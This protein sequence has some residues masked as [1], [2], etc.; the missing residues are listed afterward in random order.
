MIIFWPICLGFSGRFRDSYLNRFFCTPFVA[1]AATMLVLCGPVFGRDLS[2]TALRLEE[3]ATSQ[4]ET[5]H[6]NSMLVDVLVD[7]VPVFTFA[8]GEAMPGVPVTRE[9]HFRNGAVAL[10]YIG[11]LAL[12][13]E[14]EELV[15]LEA[16]IDRWLPDLPGADKASMRMLINMT[17]GYP[18]HVAN[19]DFIKAFYA[20]P[21]RH[22]T[23]EELIT[24]S[25]SVERRFV[26]GGNWDYSH[27][28]YVILGRVLEAATDTPLDALL[29]Q[30]VL[31]PLGLEHTRA[32]VTPEIPEPVVHA[33]TAER[34]NWEDS[35][36]WHPSWT[37][38]E[39]AVQVTTIAEMARSFDAIVGHDGFLQ[40]ESRAQMI[41]PVL[42]GFGDRLEGCPSCHTLGP[43]F[44]YGLGVMLQEDWVFQTPLFGGYASSV[45]TLP[46]GRAAIGRV[47]IAVAGTFTPDA[48]EDWTGALPNWADETVRLLAAELVPDNPPT[49]FRY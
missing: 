3:I 27:S 1:V 24:I 44:S 46:E 34:G 22:W 42:I 45:G 18:D 49:A 23:P 16:R 6:F 28:G 33:Y 48:Y 7:G 21:F 14:E 17:A 40:A 20:D 8:Q 12:R 47:T 9:G 30:Y 36:F 15:D 29:D 43:A 37:L 10:A 25:L 5:R 38:P 2:G 13:L 11:A 4:F 41:D 35:T 32:F 19:D 39:G 26:P 31:G